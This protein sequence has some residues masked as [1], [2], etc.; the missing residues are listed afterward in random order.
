M[1]GGLLHEMETYV[2]ATSAHSK[3]Q[4]SLRRS[5]SP[6]E[7]QGRME[8]GNGNGNGGEEGL[9]STGAVELSAVGAGDGTPPSSVPSKVVC[10]EGL[11]LTTATTTASSD[12]ARQRDEPLLS[13]W[14]ELLEA[15]ELSRVM[16]SGE[17]FYGF[18]EP[19]IRFPPSYRRVKGLPAGQCLDY[20]D[21]ERLKRA[22]SIQVKEKRLSFVRRFSS[23]AAPAD[24]PGSQLPSSGSAA[25]LAPPPGV[26]RSTTSK[27]DSTTTSSSRT[28]GSRSCVPGDDAGT[29]PGA[30]GK[31]TTSR[32]PSY[33]DRILV[34]T[35]PDFASRVQVGLYE[36]CDA[37][38]ASDHRPVSALLGVKVCLSAS[39][40]LQRMCRLFLPTSFTNQRQYTHLT[41]P[42]VNVGVRGLQ[43]FSHGRRTPAPAAG[44]AAASLPQRD[45]LTVHDAAYYLLEL[46]D[47][48]VEFAP[49]G[50][51]E[52]TG[53]R[54]NDN[55][56]VLCLF[57]LDNEDCFSV[58]RRPA[59][60]AAVAK[61]LA[62]LTS[63]EERDPFAFLALH[64]Y[65]SVRRRGLSIV[66]CNRPEMGGLHAS[67]AVYDYR[68]APL[69]SCVMVLSDG[70]GQ[71]VRETKGGAFPLTVGGCR[72][73]TLRCDMR[74]TQ[75]WLEGSSVYH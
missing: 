43:T 18:R 68:G 12:T 31:A 73:G 58:L 48:S 62:W 59:I 55:A 17:A 67:F 15:D 46:T 53:S 24:G 5:L 51:A 64:S 45:V 13:T 40:Y 63:E 8:E 19:A 36:L 60:V 38:T 1:M 44:A 29:A 32:V 26:G 33:T 61:N 35:F 42:K 47:V 37:L 69:G 50:A 2:G 66:S 27:H 6:Y 10:L 20:T 57:P 65:G 41:N 23:D 28:V 4:L 14:E 34:H 22:Y 3:A 72:C 7:R 52:G 49:L 21:A 70:E 16:R 9:S 75:L 71:P 39:T 11:P 56:A 25:S 54:P 74:I 30:A